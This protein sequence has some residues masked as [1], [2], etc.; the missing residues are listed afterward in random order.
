[1]NYASLCRW[2]TSARRSSAICSPASC[3][4]QDSRLTLNGRSALQG[5]SKWTCSWIYHS[6]YRK[7]KL[8]SPIKTVTDPL[9]LPCGNGHGLGS[10]KAVCASV[11]G[12]INTRLASYSLFCHVLQLRHKSTESRIRHSHIPDFPMSAR[13]TLSDYQRAR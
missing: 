10:V 7:R 5:S 8:T 9:E 3:S 4:R 13:T 6:K 12:Q 11:R 1:M 2:L